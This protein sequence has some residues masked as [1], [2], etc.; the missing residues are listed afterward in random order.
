MD[1]DRKSLV[2]AAT[3]LLRNIKDERYTVSEKAATQEMTLAD[4]RVVQVHVTVTT[5]KSKFLQLY[6]G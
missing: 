5:K 6:T 1:I 2:N 3:K 4:G